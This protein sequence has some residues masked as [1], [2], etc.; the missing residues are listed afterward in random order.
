MLGILEMPDAPKESSG[1]DRYRAGCPPTSGI[2]RIRAASLEH[3][4]D[5]SNIPATVKRPVHTH[6]ERERERE[7]AAAAR[8]PVASRESPASSRESLGEC[9]ET[10]ATQNRPNNAAPTPQRNERTCRQSR[11]ERRRPSRIPGIAGIGSIRGPLGTGRRRRRPRR[12][13]RTHGARPGH[14]KERRDCIVLR[15]VLRRKRTRRKTLGPGSNAKRNRIGRDGASNALDAPTEPS[16]GTKVDRVGERVLLR[17]KRLVDESWMVRDSRATPR[18]LFFRFRRTNAKKNPK[19]TNNE[20]PRNARR[21]IAAGRWS[22]AKF[23]AHTNQRTEDSA[24]AAAAAA[25]GG[26]VGGVGGARPASL[27]RRRR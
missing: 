20:R 16:A 13:R 21:R 26:G 14:T 1:V 27:S 25:T 22:A 11:P 6:R 24:A 19:T 15:C 5:D 23:R 18:F 2:P 8:E 10:L 9:G 12:S 7:R 4:F 3:P 17:F